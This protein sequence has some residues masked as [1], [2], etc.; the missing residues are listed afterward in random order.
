M[1]ITRKPL[2][3]SPLADLDQSVLADLAE[4]MEEL[5]RRVER[6][7]LNQSALAD[8]IENVEEFLRLAGPD[9]DEI[10]LPKVIVAKAEETS[11]R[12]SSGYKC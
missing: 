12:R 7:P 2:I 1:M 6:K 5:V 8:L 4:Y 3:Q 10:T 11:P 9:D